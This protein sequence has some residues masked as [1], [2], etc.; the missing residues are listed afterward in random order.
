MLALEL[1]AKSDGF[2]YIIGIDEAGRGPLAGPVS[3]AA[4]ALKSYD[5]S[6]PIKDSKKLSPKRRELAFTEIY[7]KAYVGTGLI[8]EAVIDDV[9]ILQATYIAMNQA[10][11]DCIDRIKTDTQKDI[12][13]KDVLLLI[14]GNTFQ[15]EYQYSYQ[16]VVKGDS[17]VFSIAAASIIAK[18]AR[19]RVLNMYDK[20]YP[21]YGFAKHKGYGTKTHREAIKKYGLS[22]AH[23][24]SFTIK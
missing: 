17:Q 9:N 4:V 22:P 1:K 14:D 18:V 13:D 2:D 16:T 12:S 10:V 20:I 6:T 19:D 15:S 3:A 8:S 23:R 24:Q 7:E 5:F 21:E 11:N